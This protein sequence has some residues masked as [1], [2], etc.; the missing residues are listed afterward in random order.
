M[1]I[2]KFIPLH[3][4]I[5][6]TL[7]SPVRAVP[8]LERA[9]DADAFYIE[10]DQS[11][12]WF[13]ASHECARQGKKLVEVKDG[14]KNG[15]LLIALNDYIGNP[16]NFWLGAND[17]YN[18]KKDPNRPFYWSSTGDRVTFTY[19]AI[20]QP[21]NLGGNEHCVHVWANVDG[22]KWNDLDCTTKLGFICE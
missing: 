22:F 8:T 2:V 5:V 16:K 11:Y 6:A 13:E 19:W 17:E 12:N 1:K 9:F 21:D 3:I 14:I 4:C 10:V 20:G 7:L 15:A 18:T